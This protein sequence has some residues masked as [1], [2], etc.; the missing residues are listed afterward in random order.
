MV[1][2]LSPDDVVS[3]LSAAALHDLWLWNVRFTQVHVTRDRRHG[4]RRTSSLYVHVAP[5]EPDDIVLIDGLAVTSVGR[6]VVGWWDDP[7]AVVGEFDGKIK[8]GRSLRPG[9]DP[10]DV[11]F[12]EKIRRGPAARRAPA[13]GPVDLAGPGRLR[14]D[15][16]T[17]GR[18]A[19]DPLSRIRWV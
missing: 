14:P 2:H 15:R 10:G 9:Q 16:P 11:V 5:L 12:E 1:P 8:Y 4:G 13:G 6:T 19:P 7:P 18:R 17:P 3:H